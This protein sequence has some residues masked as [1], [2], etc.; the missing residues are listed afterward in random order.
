MSSNTPS[1]LKRY[2]FTI[3]IVTLAKI[4]RFALEPVLDQREWHRAD[5]F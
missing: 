2:L 1:T 5:P 3:A 4:L